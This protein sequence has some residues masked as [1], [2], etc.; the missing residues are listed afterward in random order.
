MGG[1]ISFAVG[2]TILKRKQILFISVR[3]SDT[4]SGS[5]FSFIVIPAVVW[6]TKT[7]ADSGL[8]PGPFHNL[9]NF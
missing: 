1:G 6:G 7:V 2:V 8:Y 9:L 4:T 3:M 5:A